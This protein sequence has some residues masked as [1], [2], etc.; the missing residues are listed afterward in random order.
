MVYLEIIPGYS[1]FQSL[2]VSRYDRSVVLDG[3]GKVVSAVIA[4]GY[5]KIVVLRGPFKTQTVYGISKNV[6]D[7]I[8]LA[9]VFPVGTLVS[10]SFF[11]QYRK[12]KKKIRFHVQLKAGIYSVS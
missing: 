3:I 11:G 2:G 10:Y 8:N 6:S 9:R 7:K 4:T 1:I 5:I 12:R